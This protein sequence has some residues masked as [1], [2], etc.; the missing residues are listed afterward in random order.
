VIN[1]VRPLVKDGGWLVTI[2]NALFLSGAD[3]YGQLQELCADGYLAV[4]ALIPVPED[5][6][7]YAGTRVGAPPVDPAPFNHSTK[8]AVLKVKRKSSGTA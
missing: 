5:C 6:T 4:E 2:N 1:K 3:Y 7:G 8:I